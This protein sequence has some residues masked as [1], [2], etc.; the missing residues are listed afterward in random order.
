MNFQPLL[1]LGL[2]SL[3]CF[4]SAGQKSSEVINFQKIACSKDES[5][6]LVVYPKTGH[7]EATGKAHQVLGLFLNNDYFVEKTVD[8]VRVFEGEFS[9]TCLNLQA[10]LSVPISSEVVL[11]EFALSVDCRFDSITKQIPTQLF[12]HHS[13]IERRKRLTHIKY[14]LNVAYLDYNS[15]CS[16][17]VTGLAE[18]P[19]MWEKFIAF[20]ELS[21]PST[22]D[23]EELTSEFHK[24][25]F[26]LEKKDFLI[27]DIY[28]QEPA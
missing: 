25:G 6:K 22:E 28:L 12:V 4:F 19:K 21:V 1:G 15:M 10:S 9:D 16:I 23:I 11:A 14:A 17:F 3:L 7:F 2:L 24:N 27:K 26:S 8:Y 13:I 20:Q 18:S 5:I